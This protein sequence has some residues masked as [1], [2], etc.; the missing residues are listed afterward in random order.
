MKTTLTIKTVIVFIFMFLLIDQ[1][2]SGLFSSQG[3]ENFS[4][5]GIWQFRTDIDSSGIKSGWH[6]IDSANSSW[7]EMT[8]P[9]NWDTENKYAHYVGRAFYRKIFKMPENWYKSQ[10]RLKFDAVY[11]TA[12][13]WLNG[14]YLGKH[15]GGYTPFEF[16]VSGLLRFYSHNVLLVS[17]DNTYNRGAWWQWGG[18]SRDVNLIRNNDARIVYAHIESDPDLEKARINFKIKYKIQNSSKNN[19]KFNL[20]VKIIDFG[21]N[22]IIESSIENED[23]MATSNLNAGESGYLQINSILDLNKYSLWHFD[24]PHLYRIESTLTERKTGRLHHKTYE[25]MGIRKIEVIGT[26]LY[27]NGE[28]IRIN[29]F[30]R[31]HDHCVFGNTEPDEIVKKDINMMKSLGGNFSR[32]MHAP[33]AKNL[34]NYCDEAGY[35]IIEEIPVWG[36]N[37]PQ[38][39]PDNPLTK[40]WLREM[41]ER[42][43]N[44]PCI[45]GWSVANELADPDAE[46]FSERIMSREQYDYVKSMINYIDTELDSTRIKTYV[47]YSAFR[48]LASPENE[49]AEFADLININCYG[50]APEQV[51]SVHAKWPDQPIFI[52]EFGKGQIGLDPNTA[53]LDERIFSYINEI[54]EECPYVIGTS[55][56]TFNDYRSRYRGTPP[57]ENRAWGVVNIWRQPKRAAKQIQEIYAPIRDLRCENIDIESGSADVVLQPRHESDIPAYILRG[58]SINLSIY[59]K[60]GEQINVIRRELP[61]IRPGT[62]KQKIPVSWDADTSDIQLIKIELKSPQGFSVYE[63]SINVKRSQQPKIEH[64]LKAD[65]KVRIY[66]KPIFG[67]EEYICHFGTDD[68]DKRTPPTINHFIDVDSL[69]INVDYKFA[70]CSVNDKG[71]SDLSKSIQAKPAGS[72]LPPI[73]WSVQQHDNSLAIGFSVVESDSAFTLQYGDKPGKLT[74][75]L[76]SANLK[77]AIKLDG[78]EDKIYYL[79]LRRK[80]SY[81]TSQWSPVIT[82]KVTSK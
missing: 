14:K 29:G 72:P 57:S 16:D 2:Y 4:L 40:Q 10:I 69:D 44:H 78:L 25:R 71:E 48:E 37:D 17:A 52:S 58:Y 6:K 82:R 60:D 30:N 11:E 26:K 5:N 38:A 34:L 23:L 68:L 22:D 45:I 28:S 54:V 33:Q 66:F 19:L 70:I 9:G 80:G 74:N 56:W 36:M 53:I 20:S 55:L 12:E 42:D 24:R 18:I 43:F 81:G 50:V 49:P 63:K 65:G 13:V 8:V 67:A 64:V 32:I 61:E 27:L 1:T 75:E 39:F 15:V 46:N 62:L 3:E 59:N 31:V 35:M 73:V 51:G 47:S 79:H 41:I 76:S 77:G 21:E 7:D